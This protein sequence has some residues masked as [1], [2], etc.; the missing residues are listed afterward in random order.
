MTVFRRSNIRRNS[1]EFRRLLKGEGE[2]RGVL[3]DLQRRGQNIADA[4]T[5]F[6]DASKGDGPSYEATDAYKNRERAVIT[7]RAKSPKARRLEAR[8]SNL[9]TALDAGRA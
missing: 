6:D 2:Y 9:L 8:D 7:I 5:T 4:A 3:D 1:K